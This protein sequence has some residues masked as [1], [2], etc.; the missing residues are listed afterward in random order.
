MLPEIPD[1][2][3]CAF[4]T[5]GEPR[6]G[7]LVALWYRPEKVPA[8]E[9][10]VRI[11][12]L[13][14]AIPEFVA[15]PFREHPDSTVYALLVVATTNPKRQ[16]GVRCADLLAVHRFIGLAKSTRPGW[17]RVRKPAKEVEA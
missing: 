4:T 13:V 16:F 10:P 5:I 17:A 8:G 6:R 15:F 2:A 3:H 11:K 1:G 12:R 7:D 14:T 9:P